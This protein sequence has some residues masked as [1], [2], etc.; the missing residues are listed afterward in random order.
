MSLVPASRALLRGTSQLYVLPSLYSKCS[1]SNCWRMRPS[2]AMFPR[3][4][5]Q[6]LALCPSLFW[7]GWHSLF[8]SRADASGQKGRDQQR[9]EEAWGLSE[10]AARISCS[11]FYISTWQGIWNFFSRTKHQCWSGLVPVGYS[12]VGVLAGGGSSEACTSHGH[13]GGHSCLGSSSSM[14]C[15]FLSKRAPQR[16]VWFVKCSAVY[17]SHSIEAVLPGC[18]TELGRVSILWAGLLVS[19]ACSLGF[20]VPSFLCR[21]LSGTLSLQLWL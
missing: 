12:P 5:W 20:P 19:S 17:V 2:P 11:L 15:K 1:W 13:G 8:P 7:I 3:T 18:W 14:N 6:H 21:Q 16:W 9:W 4:Y 10:M